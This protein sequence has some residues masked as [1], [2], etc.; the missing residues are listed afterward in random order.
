M[1]KR[2]EKQ[3]KIKSISVKLTLGSI[4][5]IYDKTLRLRYELFMSSA[6]DVFN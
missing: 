6:T 5:N 4:V 1:K 3:N 2:K